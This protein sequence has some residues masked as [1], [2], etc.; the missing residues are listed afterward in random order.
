M[1]YTQP[2][3]I[4]ASAE[5]ISILMRSLR[6]DALKQLSNMK[7]TSSGLYLS[8]DENTA[9]MQHCIKPVVYEPKVFLRLPQVYILSYGDR[10]FYICIWEL[11]RTHNN[12]NQ[13]K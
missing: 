6:H 1:Q 7:N 13:N 3:F 10:Y 8:R 9:F 5:A 4:A 2:I 11:K 12:N